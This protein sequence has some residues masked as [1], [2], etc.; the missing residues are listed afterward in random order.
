ME[1]GEYLALQ[2]KNYSEIENMGVEVP[3]ITKKEIEKNNKVGIEYIIQYYKIIK[4][5]RMVT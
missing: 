5:V 3:T 1:L 2:W 4:I